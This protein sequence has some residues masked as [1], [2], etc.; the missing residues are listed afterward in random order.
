VHVPDAL[1]EPTQVGDRIGA[2]DD[3]MTGVEADPDP[4]GVRRV[5]QPLDLGRR[6]DVGTRVRVEDRRV[7]ERR[8]LIGDRMED[9]RQGGPSRVGERGSPRLVGAAAGR[10]A[11]GRAVDRD[12]QHVAARLV[13]FA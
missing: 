12:A 2:A 3:V 5:E 13:E 8:R 10:V 9:V 7:A 4:I 6:L 11:L 1:T